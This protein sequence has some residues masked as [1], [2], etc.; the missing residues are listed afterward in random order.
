MLIGVSE[1]QGWRYEVIERRDD[2][3][4][5]MRDLD[6]IAAIVDKSEAN[7]RQLAAR[8]RERALCPSTENRL[9]RRRA[10]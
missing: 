9:A 5:R 1:G 3:L 4:V 10:S 7:C 8:A 2:Y 6:E